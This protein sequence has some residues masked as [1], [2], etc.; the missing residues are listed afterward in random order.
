MAASSATQL[1]GIHHGLMILEAGGNARSSRP[2]VG[3][4]KLAARLTIA[5]QAHSLESVDQF[6]HGSTEQ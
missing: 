2:V 6:V 3:G 1:T 5:G 4:R